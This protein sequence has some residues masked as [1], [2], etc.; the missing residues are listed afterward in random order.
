MKL[1]FLITGFA[2]IL[3]LG[4]VAW[5]N[6]TPGSYRDCG[7]SVKYEEEM[8]CRK[9]MS[10]VLCAPQRGKDDFFLLLLSNLDFNK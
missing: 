4:F 9:S 10:T 7:C 1:L 5:M 2:L 6:L 8:A 3:F